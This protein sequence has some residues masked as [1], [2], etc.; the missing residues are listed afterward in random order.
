MEVGRDVVPGL[1]EEGVTPPALSTVDAIILLNVG[2]TA[3]LTVGFT[4][5]LKVEKDDTSSSAG[6][7]CGRCVGLDVVMYNAM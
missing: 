5:G 4:A 6:Q 3:V 7:V 1:Q 2:A